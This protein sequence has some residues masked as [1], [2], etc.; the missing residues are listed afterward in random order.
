M[1]IILLGHTRC[2]LCKVLLEES[3][4]IIGLPAFAFENDPLYEYSDDA[5]HKKCYENW[6]LRETVEINIKEALKN[7]RI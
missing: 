4:E 1:A 2:A 6:E 5:F 3:D 7:P